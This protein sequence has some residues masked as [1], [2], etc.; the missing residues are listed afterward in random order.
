MVVAQVLQGDEA[1]S[2][3]QSS[4]QGTSV[5][6]LTARSP[7]A[8]APLPEQVLAELR[9]RAWASLLTGPRN[10]LPRAVSPSGCTA[11]GLR[12]TAFPLV[13]LPPSSPCFPLEEFLFPRLGSNCQE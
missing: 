6:T 9:P 12:A 13:F 11:S 10:F 2:P 3:K 8:T 7:S 5:A 4:A 1:P